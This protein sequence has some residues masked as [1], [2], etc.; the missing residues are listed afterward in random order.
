MCRQC[1]EALCIGVVS[2]ILSSVCGSRCSHSTAELQ[3]VAAWEESQQNRADLTFTLRTTLLLSLL[4]TQDN[5]S[6]NLLLI[7]AHVSE[8]GFEY[9]SWS[10]PSL[11]YR[12]FILWF[13]IVW[14]IKMINKIHSV[15]SINTIRR[16]RVSLLELTHSNS[17]C[18]AQWHKQVF[19]WWSRWSYNKQMMWEV[20]VK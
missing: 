3:Q 19:T 17:W 11:S 9:G 16:I 15:S 18:V 10:N 7:Q 2:A 1:H 4:Q 12:S 5:T 14:L 13:W 8:L 20:T 6:K